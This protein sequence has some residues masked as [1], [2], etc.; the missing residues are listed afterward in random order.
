MRL[1]R[2]VLEVGRTLA[3][4]GTQAQH[5]AQPLLSNAQAIAADAPTPLQEPARQFQVGRHA[6]QLVKANQGDLDLLV[7]VGGSRRGVP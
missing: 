6:G 4:P 3:I 5:G 7:A 1:L 2:V